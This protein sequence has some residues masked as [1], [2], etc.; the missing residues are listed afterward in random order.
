MFDANDEGVVPI[1]R[2]PNPQ[3]GIQSFAPQSQISYLA[4][5]QNQFAWAGYVDT[6]YDILQD[7]EL[8][9]NIRY[10]NDNREDTTLTPQQFLDANPV[11]GRAAIPA[12][13]GERRSHTWDAFQPQ[14]ILKYTW[15]DDLN[16][17]ADYSRGFRSGGFNQTGVATA[18]TE[19]GFDNVGDLFNAEVADTY[20]AGFKS[21]WFDDHLLLNGSVYQTMD[22]NDYYFVFLASNST[23]NLGNIKEVRFRGFD[24]DATARID[25]FLSLNAGFGLTGSRI[26]QFPGPSSDLVVGSKAPLVSD[27]TFNVGVQYARPVWTGWNA[28]V[29]LDYNL[30]GPT[31]FV[32]PV[33]AVGEPIPKE[34][35]PV[36]LV[37]LRLGL[38]SDQWSLM[39][40]SKNLLDVKYNAEYSTGGFL[41]KAEPRQLGIELTRRF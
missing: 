32:I 11:T 33:P 26:Q 5:S 8:S 30:I 15:T 20:E 22:H 16:V 10:D 39:F 34:R 4:D 6:S 7:L 13:T 12:H 38:Q 21:R 40:W 19:A 9:L 3:F 29:R 1:Y 25:E 36:D 24:L 2:T 28:L 37:D 14:A 31:T 41:F 18:A 27:Y 35:N 17:Y 23:Q